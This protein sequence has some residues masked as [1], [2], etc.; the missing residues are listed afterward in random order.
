MESLVI[1]AFRA[2]DQPALEALWLRMF[3][4]DPPMNEPAAMIARKLTVQPE[5][6]LV[7]LDGETLVGSVIGGF[8]GVRGWINHLA[9][10]PEWRRRG[11]A[12]R[13]VRAAEDGLRAL[14]CPKVNLQ[15]RATNTGVIAF[16]ERLGYA[17][18]DRISMGRPLSDAPRGDAER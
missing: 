17:V 9:V 11:I 13:L 2:E 3:P 1:R 14:G 15:I 16:Y 8:E 4:D 10:A 12:T 5:L 7:C 18:E 6:L